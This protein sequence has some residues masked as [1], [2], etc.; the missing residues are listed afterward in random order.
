MRAAVDAF[1]VHLARVDN[2]SAH[3]VRAYVGDVVSLL[4][5]A[6]GAGCRNARRARHRRAARLAGARMAG[7]RGA[8]LAGP[9]GGG[10]PDLHR[11]G[12]P[13]RARVDRRRAPSWPAR[14]R[15]GT[16]PPCCAPTRPRAWSPHRRT[17]AARRIPAVELRDRAVLE[18][19]Y[20]TGIRVSELCGLDLADVDAARR[21]VRVFGKG[22]KERSVPYGVPAQRALDAWLRAGRPELASGSG[23][24]AVRRRARRAAAADRG[25]ARS[26]RL[27]PGRPDCRTPARTTCATR[28]PPTCSTA[29]P[30]CARCRTCWDTRRCPARRSTRTSR[31]SD[32]VPRSD[33]P[34][35]APDGPSRVSALPPPAILAPPPPAIF[36]L[37]PPAISALPPRA[38]SALSPPRSWSCGCPFVLIGPI[39]SNHNSKIKEGWERSAT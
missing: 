26:W 19:L 22:A 16:C 34:I 18:L 29:A 6:A 31:P 15:T 1:A 23:E 7:G 13:H 39:R 38:I 20:A 28:R 12:A 17:A 37:P 14:G 27:P 33:R 3:T 9:A 30:T 2:R 10:R 36:A 8:H 4:D 25:P 35:P 32:C 21:V 11:L 5:H 24:R